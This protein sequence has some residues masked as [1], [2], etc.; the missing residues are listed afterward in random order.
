MANRCCFYLRDPSY[1]RQ[2]P[3]DRRADFEETAPAARQ[4]LAALKNQIRESG[5]A[6][7][8][9][10]DP[11]SLAQVVLRDLTAA[12]N[13][14]FPPEQAPDALQRERIEHEAFAQSR[15]GVYIGR[16]KYFDRLDEHARS[17]EDGPG[18]VV[19]GD[20]GS[21]K[22]ALL[23]NWAT[24]YRQKHPEELVLMHFIGASPYSTDWTPMLRRVLDELKR[25]FTIEQEVPDQPEALRSAFANWLHMAAA[26]GRVVLILDALNQLE[27]RQGALDLAWLPAVLPGNVRLVVSTLAGRPLEELSRR[28][29]PTLT[30]EPF[31]TEESKRFIQVYLAQYG[32]SLSPVRVTRI[33]ETAATANPL[34][35]QAL[36]EELRVFGAR[37]DQDLKKRIE[38]YLAATTVD[39]LYER[40]LKRYES[41]YGQDR[42]HLVRDAMRLLWASRR[43]LSESELLD[44]L[45]NDGQPL[46]R[47]HWSPLYLAAE[48]SLVSRSGLIG[49]FHDYLRK[50]VEHQYLPN[51][52]EQRAAHLRLA[53]YFESRK[54]ESRK[55]D[56]LP[57]QLAEAGAWRRLYDML[58]DLP[59]FA[60]AWEASQFE[61]KAH[62]ARMESNSLF[63]KVEAY[64]PLLD[65]PARYMAA[66]VSRLSALLADTG[67]P[68]GAWTL[69]E[70]LVEHSRET[71]DRVN[72][73]ACFGNQ[74]LIRR[75]RGDLD[76]AMG[77]LKQ[78]EEIC[79]EL[80]NKDSLQRTLGNQAVILK[81]RGDLDGAMDLHKQQEAICREV[82]NK[83]S[84]SISLGN[85]AV[86]LKVRGDLDGAMG[87]L[88]QAEG[89]CRE[90]GKKDGLRVC[91]GNQALILRVRGDLDGAMD[92]HKQEEEICRE[93]GNKDSLSI[94]LGNQALIH[95][96]RGDLDGAMDLHRQ[97]E[98]ICRELG[99]KDG[100]QRTLGHQALIHRVRGDLDGAMDLHKQEEEICRELDDK[101]SLSISL[102][103]QAVILKAGGDLDGAMDLHKQEEEICR[104]LGNKDSL[105]RTLGNQALILDALG[106]LHGA[107][108]LH[109]QQ[110]AICRELGI[111]DGLVRSLVN[112]ALLLSRKMSR[113]KD[114]LKLVEEGYHLATQHGLSA[115]AGQ[116]KPI[117]DFCSGQGR[118]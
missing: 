108:D 51:A 78:A 9:Y 118:T 85:Q 90:L 57:W 56:E 91:F 49:F 28:A 80:G 21:G 38:H 2:I 92:L 25:W 104:E 30:V 42:E 61:V 23:A 63:R 84:L 74:A 62:W 64:R 27:D 39:G 17:R 71:G 89:I 60:A 115:L 77:L 86:I 15:T 5:L 109:K 103:N 69:Q 11:E 41:D 107:M 43:G 65:D 106:D 6:W 73:Q 14:E 75:A 93:L 16:Q 95:Q 70:Y 110:E 94:S 67:H 105:Q 1:V 33:A 87:L 76:G 24:R 22:S 7:K 54:L 116:I 81:D 36:L 72:L 46:A 113:P 50:A 45:G 112:Q 114:G 4:K 26:R 97:Q 8:E 34:Y 53:E 18:L 3:P 35:L 99:N 20:S 82:G 37:K 66:D 98:A 32:K 40:I 96:V 52:E 48:R 55:I 102:G 44:L 58:A 13:Q 12:I 59:F 100:L 79:R 29:W 101:D 10:S 19:L 47:A 117:L 111:V 83:D 68:A 88:K 31:K